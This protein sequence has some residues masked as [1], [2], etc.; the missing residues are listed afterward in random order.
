[1]T[2]PDFGE[3]I[4]VV[5]LFYQDLIKDTFL[6]SKMVL[7]VGGLAY[8]FNLTTFASLVSLSHSHTIVQQFSFSSLFL[9]VSKVPQNLSYFS[10]NK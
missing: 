2:F 9:F 8:A 10:E 7:S 3:C 1:M 4:G 6:L 5:F